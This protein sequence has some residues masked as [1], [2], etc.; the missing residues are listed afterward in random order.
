MALVLT[1]ICNGMRPV[2]GVTKS[3]DRQGEEWKF[4]SLEITDTRYGKVYSCQVR[5]DDPSYKEFVEATSG[6]GGKLK[7]DLTGHKVKVTIKGQTA[8]EREIE[9]KAKGDVR[10]IMQIRS[11]VTNVKDLGVPEEDE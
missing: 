2:G 9:D 10:I 5:D 4:L 1:G 7:T 3:G 8:S 6:N 11:Q